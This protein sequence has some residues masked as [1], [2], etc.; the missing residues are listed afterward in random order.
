LRDQRYDP[1]LGGPGKAVLDETLEPGDTLYLPRGWLHEAVTSETDSL[2]LTIGINVQTWIDAFR[3]ALDECA[4]DVEFRRSLPPDGETDV[5]FLERL[6]PRLEPE[7]V[8][9]RARRRFVAARRPIRHGRL[10]EL[11]ALERLSLSTE[12]ER[13]PTVIADLELA[14]DGGATLVFEGKSVSFPPAAGIDVAYVHAAEGAFRPSDLPGRLDD[15]G[16]LVLVRRL[17]REGFARISGRNDG[18]SL[19]TSTRT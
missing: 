19:A 1:E 4:D 16:R 12:I 15:A 9:R 8:A 11:R 10:G 7:Q 18:G 2:H 3:A 14:D 17:V 13:N 6:R 5:D